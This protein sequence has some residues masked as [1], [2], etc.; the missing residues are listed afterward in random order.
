[1]TTEHVAA[2]INP[3]HVAQRQFD[4]AADRFEEAVDWG[5]TQAEL[6]QEDVEFACLDPAVDLIPVGDVARVD[7]CRA[8]PGALGGGPEPVGAAVDEAL[9]LACADAIVD[10]SGR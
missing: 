5:R 1:M 10:G 8:D 4:L 3:W 7:G 6:I 9:T 2:T